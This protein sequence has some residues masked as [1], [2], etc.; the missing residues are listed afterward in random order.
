MAKIPI[1]E[2]IEAVKCA[3]GVIEESWGKSDPG[4]DAALQTLTWLSHHPE[5]IKVLYQ[6][7][8]HF[9]KVSMEVK[10]KD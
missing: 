5:L 3:K 10:E 7:E 2:Q 1:E 8:K 4:L 6:L 9:P